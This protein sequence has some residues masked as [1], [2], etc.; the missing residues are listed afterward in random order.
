MS[1]DFQELPYDGGPRGTRASRA[2]APGVNEN[3]S[4]TRRSSGSNEGD[5]AKCLALYHFAVNGDM[6]ISTPMEPKKIASP[7]FEILSQPACASALAPSPSV[8]KRS[9]M[10]RRMTGN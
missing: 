1:G 2:R 5:T 9:I 10:V 7:C 6:T 3:L 4:P 8:A